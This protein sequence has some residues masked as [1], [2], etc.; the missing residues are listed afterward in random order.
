MVLP[1]GWL[2]LFFDF[3]LVLVRSWGVLFTFFFCFI[4]YSIVIYHQLCNPRGRSF[5]VAQ[6]F[7]RIGMRPRD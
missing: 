5:H 2:V 1:F 7:H 6:P 4:S 3:A